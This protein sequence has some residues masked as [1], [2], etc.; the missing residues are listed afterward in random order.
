MIAR[1]LS[2][3]VLAF[4]LTGCFLVPEYGGPA[5]PPP[6][7]LAS[8]SQTLEVDPYTTC[9]SSGSSTYCAD[10]IPPDPLPDLGRVSGP[11]AARFE[12][13]DWDL[14]ASADLVGDGRGRH[15]DLPMD[16]VSEQTWSI[17]TDVP[18]GTYEI[19]LS[20]RGP[21]GDIAMAFQLTVRGG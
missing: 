16:Q 20:G 2:S 4:V 13:D 11:V 17:G 7:L 18:G 12:V 8:G 9:W 14:Q 6:V 15:I 19:W 10:G 1:L 21:Q 3:T 5:S